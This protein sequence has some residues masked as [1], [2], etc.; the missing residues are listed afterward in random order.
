[1]SWWTHLDAEIPV[2]LSRANYDRTRKNF[3][4]VTG[5]PRNDEVLPKLVP[6]GA[7]LIRK[8]TGFA[9]T[10]P[11]GGNFLA[12][13]STVFDDPSSDYALPLEQFYMTFAE[14]EASA[15][16][17]E[18]R[19]P[20]GMVLFTKVASPDFST[21]LY[22]EQEFGTQV[23]PPNYVG[24]WAT[25]NRGWPAWY[26]NLFLRPGGVDPH[27]DEWWYDTPWG[28]EVAV[29][30]VPP[31][32]MG[33]FG[34]EQAVMS[35]LSEPQVVAVRWPHPYIVGLP[36]PTEKRI[37]NLWWAGTPNPGTQVGLFKSSVIATGAGGRQYPIL[38][39]GEFWI[40]S[41]RDKDKKEWWEN[42]LDVAVQTVAR[43]T[44]LQILIQT[45]GTVVSAG[46]ASGFIQAGLSLASRF[47]GDA[48]VK[49][50]TQSDLPTLPEMLRPGYS[51]GAG[52]AAQ[53]TQNVIIEAAAEIAPEALPVVAPEETNAVLAEAAKASVVLENLGPVQELYALAFRELAVLAQT[54]TEKRDALRVEL[55]GLRA[56]LE[57]QDWYRISTEVWEKGRLIASGLALVF[58]GGVEALAQALA[59]LAE[60]ALTAAST[61][62]KI[63]DANELMRIARDQLE[64][65]NQAELSAYDEEIR[66]VNAEIADLER[67]LAL[68]RERQRRE[69]STATPTK[70]IGAGAVAFGLALLFL[71]RK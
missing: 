59:K 53:G 3:Y 20:Y 36:E 48:V 35:P 58:G 43:E 56:K 50:L 32:V 51:Q 8:V 2:L 42:A 13:W 30:F 41:Y 68:L 17:E 16:R 71:G 31:L 65:Q 37:L 21:A 49:A 55:A 63:Q 66:R 19:N 28:R 60:T 9:L 46:A 47:G 14:H 15:P 69:G 1:M 23:T 6:P 54:S 40:G 62:L 7:S 67:R 18:V 22:P 44:A 27:S 11:G 61:A 52:T 38:E 5:M 4:R 45:V 33:Q 24:R 57:G 26:G 10:R 29:T 64:A 12:E 34:F 39:G 25:S 70:A